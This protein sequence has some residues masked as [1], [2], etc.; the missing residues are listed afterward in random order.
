MAALYNM[1]SCQGGLNWIYGE[2]T[3]TNVLLSRWF[4]LVKHGYGTES[5][6]NVLKIRFALDDLRVFLVSYE[7][8]GTLSIYNKYNVC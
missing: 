3:V 5:W 8:Y 2:C 6:F 7:K 4:D 1:F